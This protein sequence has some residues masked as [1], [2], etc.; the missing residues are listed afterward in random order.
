[1]SNDL[2]VVIVERGEAR[3]WWSR[4]GAGSL[5][6]ALTEGE[7]AFTQH[8]E[9]AHDPLAPVEL[10]AWMCGLAVIDRDARTLGLWGEATGLWRGAVHALIASRWPGWR[11]QPLCDLRGA[12]GVHLRPLAALGVD[13]VSAAQAEVWAA[14]RDADAVRAWV[15]DA[16]EPLVREA[17]E[18]GTHDLWLTV[19]DPGGA[20][21]HD[22]WVGGWPSGRALTIGEAGVRAVLATRPDHGVPL[23]WDGRFRASALVD[24]ATRTLSLWQAAPVHPD[25]LLGALEA[26][27]PGWRVSAWPDQAAHLAA[28]GLPPTRGWGPDTQRDLDAAFARGF[29]D[30]PGAHD[31]DAL[32]A[33]FARWCA[34]HAPGTDAERV[35]W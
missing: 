10:V 12:S 15:A 20:C 33:D 8:V 27:W 7:A 16:G 18:W 14:Q 6:L 2:I 25:D 21:R 3:A 4:W 31:R 13:E 30:R 24:V 19:R 22:A 11:L 1:M 34:D 32:A 17:L 9:R 26:S 35:D 5:A 23:A 29:G 28:L